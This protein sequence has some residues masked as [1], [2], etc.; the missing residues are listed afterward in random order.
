MGKKGLKCFQAL[1]LFR[2]PVAWRN[3][4]DQKRFF[5]SF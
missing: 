2:N 1:G 3:A 4:V 5:S